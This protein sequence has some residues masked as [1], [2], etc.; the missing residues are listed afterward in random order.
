VVKHRVVVHRRKLE[1][2]VAQTQQ[3]DTEHQGALGSEHR[4][5]VD[6]VHGEHAQDNRPGK[7]SEPH[8]AT[9][10]SIGALARDGCE[11][12]DEQAR[13]RHAVAQPRRGRALIREDAI[14]GQVRRKNEG[15][16][17]RVEG[18]AAPVPGRPV[19]DFACDDPAVGGGSVTH[20]I[21]L[22]WWECSETHVRP[23]RTYHVLRHRLSRGR[24]GAK[25]RKLQR[26]LTA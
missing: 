15:G 10:S 26:V 1:E 13:D 18:G 2:H 6:E 19:D 23:W 4:F 5:G 21:G 24:T 7:P 9:A 11:E 17:H 14:A 16:G 8:P 3:R 20:G 22:L 12:R 25:A